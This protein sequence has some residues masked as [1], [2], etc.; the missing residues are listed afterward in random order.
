MRFAKVTFLVYWS[1]VCFIIIIFLVKSHKVF[2]ML[3]WVTKL[4]QTLVE[5]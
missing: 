4:N 1:F 5:L 3:I 2:L